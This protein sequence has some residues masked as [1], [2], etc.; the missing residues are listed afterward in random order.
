M[1][2][3]LLTLAVDLLFSKNVFVWFFLFLIAFYVWEAFR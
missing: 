3:K 2:A 1:S